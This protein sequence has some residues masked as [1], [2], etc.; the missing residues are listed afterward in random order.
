[1]NTPIFEYVL[2]RLEASKGRWPVIAEG[3]GVP[4]RTVQKIAARLIEDPGVSHI[5]KLH[6]YFRAL[7]AASVA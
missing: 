6:D 3:S 2:E 4:Y 1:M 7:E 5:Q